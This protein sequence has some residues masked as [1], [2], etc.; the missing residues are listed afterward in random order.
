MSPLQD[1][2]AL[3]AE[4]HAEA[5]T[6]E[7]VALEWIGSIEDIPA[8]TWRAC[9]GAD[10]VLHAY[11]LHQ[12]TEAAGLDGVEFHYLLGRQAGEVVAVL[13]CFRYRVS[14]TTVASAGMNRAVARV[15][16]LWPGFLYLNIFIAGT[17]IAICKDLIGIRFVPE[18]PRYGALMA[19]LAEGVKAR[20]RALGIGMVLIKE[21]TRALLPHLQGCLGERFTFVESP[22][23]TYLYLG[24][25]Q[26]G[27]YRERLRKK[28]R[29]LMNNRQRR[30]ADAGYEWRVCRDFAPWAGQM[31]D[32]YR[33]VL[34][35]AKIRFET[36]NAAFFEEVARRLGENAF[37]V[38]VLDG[39]RLIAFELFVR[40]RDWLHPIYL[41]MSYEDRDDGALYFNLIY[42]IVEIVEAEGRPLVQLGQTSYAAKAGIGAVAERLYLAVANNNPLLN[43]LVRRFGDALFPPTELARQQRTFRDME[44]NN[45][46]LRRLGVDFEVAPDE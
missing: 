14:L 6:A 1:Q 7:P 15:R 9:F 25:P 46:A 27:S 11:E 39:E 28:Y 32:L 41:G 37:A 10:D 16:R 42:K 23:T 18:D 8:E 45:N 22:A 40:D 43:A 26:T 2:T 31:E 17:P 30:F 3:A 12:A 33:Q 38:L 21:I 44:A 34:D 24:E 5:G 19:I 29:S 20:A 4:P 36:L 13:P 35:R